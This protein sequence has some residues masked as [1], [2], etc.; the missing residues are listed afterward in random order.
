MSPIKIDLPSTVDNVPQKNSLNSYLPLRNKGNDFNWDVVVGLFLGVALR[1]EIK[2]CTLEEFIHDCHKAFENK[3]DDHSFWRVLEKMY[4]TNGAFYKVAPECLLF[5]AQKQTISAADERIALMYC[6]LLDGLDLSN[7]LKSDLN[8]L[9][10][11]IVDVLKLKI[12]PGGLTNK[13]QPYLPFLS[14]YFQKDLLF[15]S[16]K[17]K[18]LL[19]ELQNLLTIYG[20]LYCS[21]LALNL[22]EWRVGLPKSRPLYFIMDNEK[23]S[24]ERTEIQRSGWRSFHDAADYLFPMLSM[25][26]NLQIDDRTIKKQP[27][28]LMADS[29]KKEKEPAVFMESIR[30]FAIAFK[31]QRKLNTVFKQSDYVLDWL[32]NL[33]KLAIDQFQKG[34]I[35]STR[36][37][38]N[39]NYVKELEIQ[40]GGAFIQSRGRAGRVLVIN[41]DN[42]ILLTNIAIGKEEKLRFH[43]LILAFEGRGIY[44][45][46]QSQLKLIEFYERIGNVDRMSDS[47]DAVYVRKTV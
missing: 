11:Q 28:W 19:S 12:T 6:A 17:P 37:D 43:E 45:D 5:S 13:E 46:K 21:Q 1:Q 18:Y 26:E 44:F 3:L 47:G 16:S 2:S 40:V 8:F 39:K 35:D 25:L 27:L 15:L 36:Y 7:I 23:A 4:F 24:S 32:E 41:Q 29:L 31:E 34:L 22:R 33:M 38:I 42:I 9:E 14:D 30:R 20:F 10:Q